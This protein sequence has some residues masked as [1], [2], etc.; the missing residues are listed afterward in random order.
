MMFRSPLKTQCLTYLKLPKLPYSSIYAEPLSL[1]NS[2]GPPIVTQENIVEV[3]QLGTGQFGEVVL[4]NTTGL[5]EY[6][7]QLSPV[8]FPY[9]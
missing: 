3:K 1:D 4:A 7:L 6:Y 8:V 9:K 2:K 5:S